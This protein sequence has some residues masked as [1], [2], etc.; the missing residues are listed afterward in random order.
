MKAG[1][2]AGVIVGAAWIMEVAWMEEI[3]EAEVGV[4]AMMAVNDHNFLQK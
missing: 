1:E 2:Q 4:A 3:A